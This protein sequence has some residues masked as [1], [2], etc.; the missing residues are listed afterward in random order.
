MQFNLLFKYPIH[1]IHI[2]LN[3]LFKYP[4]HMKQTKTMTG[5]SLVAQWLR[6]CPARQ[7]TCV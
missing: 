5:T 6:I 7:G 4:I 1:P 2:Q 3:L